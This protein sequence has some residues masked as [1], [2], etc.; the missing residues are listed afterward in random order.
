MHGRLVRRSFRFGLRNPSAHGVSRATSSHRCCVQNRRS[1]GGPGYYPSNFA[2]PPILTLKL[3][4][5]FIP[6]LWA[7]NCCLC[8]PQSLRSCA[9]R[10]RLLG[11]RCTFSLNALSLRIDG[12]RSKAFVSCEICAKIIRTAGKECGGKLS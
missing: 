6:L 11:R 5:T 9:R 8:S 10:C 7:V 3:R 2:S 12:G 1:V 4:L